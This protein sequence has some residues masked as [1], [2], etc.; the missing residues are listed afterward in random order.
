[1]GC[2][3]GDMSG[4]GGWFRR[5]GIFGYILVTLLI[6]I[7][8]YFIIE[9]QAHLA[10]YS[11]IIFL[12]IFIGLHLVMCGMGHGS[13]GSHGS[14]GEPGTKEGDADEGKGRVGEDEKEKPG[15]GCH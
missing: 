5:L 14:H 13:H 3:G 6:I 1:M 4:I 12:V 2:C 15:G 10:A 7:A 9:H 11:T 8:A